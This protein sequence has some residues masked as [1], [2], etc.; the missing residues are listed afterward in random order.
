MEE[1]FVQTLPAITVYCGS[2]PGQKPIYAEM[3]AELAHLLTTQGIR[4]VYGGGSRGLMG[5]L[6]DTM[7]RE[8]GSV[9]GVIPDFMRDLEWAH[10]GIQDMRIVRTM[11]ERKAQMLE[12]GSGMITLPGGIG[13]LEE[14]SEVV[15]WSQLHIHEKPVGILNVDGY[16]DSFLRFLTHMLQQGFCPPATADLM[17][18]DSDPQRL[19]R[20]MAEFRHHRLPKTLY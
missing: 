1:R 10:P 16:Y 17:L 20:R 15:S 5:V 12:L 11:S 4:L 9:T 19:L 2:S 18:V 8:G 13:T 14:F 6:A 3:A 7:L